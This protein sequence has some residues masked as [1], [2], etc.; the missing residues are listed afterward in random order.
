[1]ITFDRNSTNTKM[2]AYEIKQNVS[3]KFFLLLRTTLLLTAL[4]TVFFLLSLTT[5][6]VLTYEN[7]FATTLTP[8]KHR[9]IY[10]VEFFVDSIYSKTIDIRNL[11]TFSICNFFSICIIIF[12]FV[13]TFSI[14]KNLFYL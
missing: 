5:A 4:R 7:N 10:I 1:M 2:Y 14:C 12:L 13:K 8:P 11:K 9:D 6:F 3:K